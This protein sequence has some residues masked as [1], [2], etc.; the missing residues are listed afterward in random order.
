MRIYVEIS[1]DNAD[2]LM[3]LARRERRSPRQQAELLLDE[4]I[5]RADV[6]RGRGSHDEE[7]LHTT[8]KT[9]AAHSGVAC[10]E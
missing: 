8:I 9:Q 7:V 2:K 10:V 1:K 5:E 3:E 6:P 4:A